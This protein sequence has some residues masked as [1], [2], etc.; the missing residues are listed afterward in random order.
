MGDYSFFEYASHEAL[1]LSD[2]EKAMAEQPCP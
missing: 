2:D 1:H